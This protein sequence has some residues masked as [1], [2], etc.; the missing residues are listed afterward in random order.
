MQHPQQQN[1]E[2]EDKIEFSLIPLFIYFSRMNW[3]VKL[4]EIIK[5]IIKNRTHIR[6][7]SAE[8]NWNIFLFKVL[9]IFFQ[10]KVLVQISLFMLFDD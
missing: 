8:F 3:F 2:E 4:I 1:K 7:C 9:L 6:L 5:I 10:V